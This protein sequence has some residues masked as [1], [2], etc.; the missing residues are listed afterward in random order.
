MCGG[1]R[2]VMPGVLARFVACVAVV[3]LGTPVARSAQTEL[4]IVRE[5][6]PGAKEYH[7]PGCPLVREANNSS[8][9]RSCTGSGAGSLVSTEDSLGAVV[10]QKEYYAN[11]T[12]QE[13]SFDFTGMQSGIYTVEVKD[14]FDLKTA[15]GRVIIR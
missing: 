13:V 10:A 15:V 1:L 9:G 3:M 12:Y 14:K 4:V 7:R 5:A 2:R 8:R 11:Q 6:A